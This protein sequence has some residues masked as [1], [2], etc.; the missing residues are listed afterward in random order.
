M[1]FTSNLPGDLYTPAECV[2]QVEYFTQ[3]IQKNLILNMVQIYIMKGWKFLNFYTWWKNSWQI[4]SKNSFITMV[5]VKAAEMTAVKKKTQKILQSKNYI[6]FYFLKPN[7]EEQ[8]T[9]QF[10]MDT[11]VAEEYI[12]YYA[13]KYKKLTREHKFAIPLCKR[14][15]KNEIYNAIEATSNIPAGYYITAECTQDVEKFA[16]KLHG[17][18]GH[19]DGPFY[20]DEV[21]IKIFLHDLEHFLTDIYHTHFF[22]LN[23]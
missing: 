3:Q 14:T 8:E 9:K 17:K 10:H 19:K 12:E 4:F 16:Q 13:D 2:E 7:E 18:F 11:A 21:A 6:F 15:N 5:K 23:D 1:R 20:A 22:S